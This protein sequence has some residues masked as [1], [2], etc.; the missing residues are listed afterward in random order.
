MNPSKAG[1]SRI[2]AHLFADSAK[3]DAPTVD[4]DSQI[5]DIS[6]ARFWQ[7]E[8]GVDGVIPANYEPRYAYPLIV[9]LTDE[10]CGSN[11]A[12]SNIAAMSPQNYTGITV[13]AASLDET[14]LDFTAGLDDSVAFLKSLAEVE[15]RIVSA[16][17]SCREVINIHTE[18]IFLAGAFDAATQALLIAMHQPDWFGGCISFGGRFPK[19]AGILGR[20]C[21]L[22]DCRFLLAAEGG[23]SAERDTQAACRIARHLVS[24][25]ADVTSHI[26]DSGRSTS[27]RML[28]AVDEWVIAGILSDAA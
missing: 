25:G 9:W 26:D 4:V 2:P 28:R 11:Q 23:R 16:V 24:C 7:V 19:A 27:P 12:L 8:E 1:Q 3:P 17:R 15:S 18:R 20:D 14:T 21:R 22:A 6:L 5:P 13:E 10:S